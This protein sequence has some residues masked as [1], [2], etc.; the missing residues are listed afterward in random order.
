MDFCIN[1]LESLP[2]M[3]AAALIVVIFILFS[4][5]GVLLVR[6]FI[7]HKHLK[8]HHDVASVVYANLGVLYA[9]LL[10]FTVVNVQQRFDSIK[11]T[12]EIEASYL[13]DLYRD[14][15]VFPTENRNKIKKAI[16]LYA[17][18]IIHE[19]W[20]LMSKGIQSESTVKSLHAIWNAYYE[21]DITSLKQDAWYRES[22]S[23]LNN[24]MN[25]RISRLLGS[26]ESL[27][28]EMWTFLILGG[29]IMVGF[30]WFFGLDNLITHLLMAS[31]LA[32]T[33]AFLLF[34]IYSLDTAFSGQIQVPSESIERV[35]HSFEN[36]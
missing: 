16:K 15:E 19:E 21:V 26:Y 25:A 36:T 18:N 33:T 27:G 32:A 24:L 30:I 17:E 11:N 1:C 20:S 14:A 23:K 35:L 29:F 8:T 7:G 12:T 10:G 2:W 6:K 34:L 22:I 13:A 28:E 5:L 3:M 9:V 4:I 31:I